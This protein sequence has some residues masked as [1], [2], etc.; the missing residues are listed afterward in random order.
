MDLQ[1]YE[2]V[3]FEI[4]ENFRKLLKEQ[5]EIK[6]RIKFSWSNWGFGQENIETSLKRLKKNNVKYIELL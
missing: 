4:K 5:G 2:K 1:N 6:N 3:D